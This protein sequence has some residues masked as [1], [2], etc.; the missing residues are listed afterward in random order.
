M[1]L[2]KIP[3]QKIEVI[4]NGYE[5]LGVESSDKNNQ[6]NEEKI[7]DIATTTDYI[8][9]VGTIQPRK[10]ISTLLKAF[11]KFVQ[12]NPTYKLILVGKKGWMY[13]KIF[14]EVTTLNLTNSVIFT[15]FLPDNTVSKLYQNAFCYVLPSL[16]EG[17][18]IPILEAMAHGSPVLA[19]YASSLPEIG[20]EACLYFD[21]QNPDDLA[22]KLT[23]LKAS[24]SL[25]S[26][27]IKKGKERIT[28]FSWDRCG[29]QTLEVLMNSYQK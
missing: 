22:D 24:P 25:R 20:G 23:M 17:F 12:S 7:K 9:Y 4:Y 10:N 21:P 14:E 29:K 13:E 26:D 2:Y 18:G 8:L 28:L 27:L 1:K 16:Y 6:S 5:K 19:S 15:G 11:A 3:D